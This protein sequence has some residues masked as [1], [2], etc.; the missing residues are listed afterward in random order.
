MGYRDLSLRIFLLDK[1]NFKK[2][3]VS[4][5]NLDSDYNGDNGP[6]YWT[7]SN[8]TDEGGEYI[9][10]ATV[11]GF[12]TEAERLVEAIYDPGTDDERNIQAV[13]DHIS[14]CCH[15]DYS[16]QFTYEIAMTKT[17]CFV[18]VSYLIQ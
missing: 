4:L 17:H 15:G 11:E 8:K 6:E 10:L 1:R 5:F 12:E 16:S 14:E 3:L 18:A 2:E 9:P 13:L 7:P